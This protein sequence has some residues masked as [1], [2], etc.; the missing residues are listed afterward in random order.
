MAIVKLQADEVPAE[1]A[2]RL[3]QATLLGS[4]E[5]ARLWKSSRSR[6]VCW[7]LEEAGT[8]QALLAGVEFGPNWLG[9][10]QS[11]PDGLYSRPIMLDPTIDIQQS[12]ARLR[13]GIL[14][15]SYGRIY[16][17]DYYGLFE[18][19]GPLRIENS[20]TTLVDIGAKDWVPPDKKIQSEIRKAEREGVKVEKFDASRHLPAFLQLVKSTEKRHGREPFYSEQF[21]L[22]LAG[23]AEDDSR[24]RW[25]IVEHEGQAAAS[26]IYFIEGNLLLNWQVYFDKQFSFLKPNQ[27]LTWTAAREAAVGGVRYLNLGSSPEEAENLQ[28]YKT[29]W[30]GEDRTYR[31]YIK[32]DSLVSRTLRRFRR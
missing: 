31:T 29:K 15:E 6:P 20:H 13:D 26:H 18:P 4:I 27:Y 1:A 2:Q 11:M 25:V 9:S 23:L 30:G 21:Y 22:D 5:L 3:R 19:L 14:E 7:A 10:F 8:I 24:I 12:A 17:N 16:L 32:D 28:T